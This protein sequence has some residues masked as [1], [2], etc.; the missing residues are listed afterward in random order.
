MNE[1]V[2]CLNLLFCL[3]CFSS[4]RR[5]CELASVFCRFLVLIIAS[6]GRS[7]LFTIT[8]IYLFVCL[9]FRYTH[10][11]IQNKYE[12]CFFKDKHGPR[13]E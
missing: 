12:I 8:V 9:F 10:G 3:F 4:P 5:N 1:H 11:S 13:D 6:L 7:I 2:L